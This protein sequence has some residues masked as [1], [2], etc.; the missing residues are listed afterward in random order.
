MFSPA[1]LLIIPVHRLYLVAGSYICDCLDTFIKDL[2][3]EDCVCADGYEAV[4]QVCTDI[5]EC[6]GESECGVNEVSA[7]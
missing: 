4:E 2:K 5:N 1:K 7:V 6:A 3:S